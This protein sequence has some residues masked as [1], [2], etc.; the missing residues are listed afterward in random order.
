MPMLQA[1]TNGR[2]NRRP[3]SE[4]KNGGFVCMAGHGTAGL[5]LFGHNSERKVS[6]HVLG[7]MPR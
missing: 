4:T 3:P 2:M 5:V 1:F 6:A 7:Q